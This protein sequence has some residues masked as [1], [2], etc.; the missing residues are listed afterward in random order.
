MHWHSLF[1]WTKNGAV[2]LPQELRQSPTYHS[3]FYAARF[4][5]LFMK[6]VV[7]STAEDIRSR[8]L[9]HLIFMSF[10]EEVSSKYTD[11]VCHTEVRWLTRAKVIER[12]IALKDEMAM[13]WEQRQESFLNQRFI[14]QRRFIFSLRLPKSSLTLSCKVD[15]SGF[16]PLRR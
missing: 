13:F 7:V 10:L 4:W 2:V 16:L 5:K 8:R 9:K 15:G 11:L 6:F 3:R 1:D 14:I 12:V